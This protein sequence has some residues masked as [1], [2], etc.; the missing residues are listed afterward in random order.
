MANQ[1]LALHYLSPHCYTLS[2]VRTGS[3][4]DQLIRSTVIV[5]ALVHARLIDSSFPLLVFGAGAAGM[6]AAL[7]AARCGVHST[8][9]EKNK[10]KFSTF[11]QAYWRRIDP[12]E[13]DWPH[14]H[15]RQGHFP[16]KGKGSIPF[17]QRT[18]SG[19][20]LASAWKAEW[21][22]FNTYHN[23]PASN[24]K[25]TVIHDFDA[26]KLTYKD[27]H[28]NFLDVHGKW[29]AG[30]PAFSRQFGALLCCD[31]FGSEQVSEYPNIG[32]W[33]QYQGP[34]FWHDSD[35]M[36][37]GSRLPAGVSN[38]II[39]GGGDGG[40]QDLQ[41][42]AT[43][44]FGRQLYEK[45]IAA[46]NKRDSMLPSDGLLKD[47]LSA[48]DAGRRAF[49]W[50]PDRLGVPNALA[51]WHRTFETAIDRLV[52][53]WT[54]VEIDD[55]AD[56]LF[57]PAVLAGSLPI[58]WVLGEATP[59]YAD[60]L[61]RYLVLMLLAI[62]RRY[63]DN[64]NRANPGSAIDLFTV[65]PSSRIDTI[66]P[67]GHSCLN[68]KNCIGKLHEV[69]IL[70]AGGSPKTIP[71]ANLIIVRHGVRPRRGLVGQAQIPEQIVPFS[72]PH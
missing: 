61:N 23:G 6:N 21:R 22:H 40:M 51:T 35:G 17:P 12:T 56:A 70:V 42:V 57:R 3:V 71:N 31:G 60:A 59:G 25:V 11:A 64:R 16:V 13:Y 50:A 20:A 53:N 48:E 27:V 65:L 55:M 2:G 30:L 38:A 4:R 67:L 8:V 46:A 72:L 28:P 58:T 68:A 63:T 29:D 41:R 54:D 69:T 18:S 15:W 62:A 44:Y 36:V 26:H 45:Y 43:S 39:S 10:R 33:N 7:H 34:T 19:L 1:V 14:E 49:G 52:S 9:V 32:K 5:N 24:P 37:P 47:L 66:D